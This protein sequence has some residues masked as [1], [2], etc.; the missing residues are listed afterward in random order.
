MQLLWTYTSKLITASK[1]VSRPL[2]HVVLA[3]VGSAWQR[4]YLQIAVPLGHF[5][6]D[7]NTGGDRNFR[8]I[9]APCLECCCQL[10]PLHLCTFAFVPSGHFWSETI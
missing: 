4:Y 7:I 8:I 5:I 10:G 3:G 2:F 9:A 6:G 1:S